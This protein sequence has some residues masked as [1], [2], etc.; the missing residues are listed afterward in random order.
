MY[1]LD[2]KIDQLTKSEAFDKLS[3]PQLIFTPNPEII[4]EAQNNKAF[5]NALKNG[6][7]MLADGHG[8]LLVSTLLKF[9]SALLRFFLLPIA[10]ILFLFSKRAFKSVIPEIIHGSD[11][12]DELISWSEDNSKSVFFLGGDEGVSQ[13]TAFFFK[14]RYPDLYVAGYSAL[15]P[16]VEAYEMVKWSEADVVLVAYGAPKQEMWIS[17]YAP[18]LKEVHIFMAVGGSFDFWSGKVKRAPRFMRKL[19]L[20]WFWRLL[21]QPIKRSKRIWN[22]FVRFPI[23]SLFSS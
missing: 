14:E 15:N 20:E 22:A 6:T 9:P 16:G 21:L 7:L 23:T 18:K 12:M 3:E 5:K 13:N 17:K 1:I 11:F 10:L 19:G 2:V 8:L 4:L